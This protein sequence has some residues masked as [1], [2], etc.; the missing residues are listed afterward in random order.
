MLGSLAQCERRGGTSSS[1][2]AV[3]TRESE[4][5]RI[6]PASPSPYVFLLPPPSESTAPAAYKRTEPAFVILHF[7]SS[8]SPTVSL[9]SFPESLFIY[10]FSTFGAFDLFYF[11]PLDARA[12][13]G[14]QLCPFGTG[15]HKAAFSF[16]FLVSI[17]RV[18]L[19]PC[20][21]N[22]NR[23]CFMS[24]TCSTVYFFLTP[25]KRAKQAQTIRRD[26]NVG[27][28]HTELFSALF[29]RLN[30]YANEKQPFG[31][32]YSACNSIFRLRV[33]AASRGR[34]RMNAPCTASA[35][36]LFFFS[37]LVYLQ[38][39]STLNPYPLSSS[40][41]FRHLRGPIHLKNYR[42]NLPAKECSADC[43]AQETQS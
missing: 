29:T 26:A 6:S 13:A 12:C 30:T 32:L 5:S 16:L 35:L 4:S 41:L 3:C 27:G 36:S 7:P 21:I 22:R 39:T 20:I 38:K 37:N 25:D 33:V 24:G 10:P 15:S 43:L 14:L 11:C 28:P 31:P 17:I 1:I 40:G 34:T 9:R 19:S 2:P 42:S 23:Q 18:W 8:L